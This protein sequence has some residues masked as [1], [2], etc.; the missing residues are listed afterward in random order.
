MYKSP[1]YRIYTHIVLYHKFLPKVNQCQTVNLTNSPQYFGR[2]IQI[3]AFMAVQYLKRL[4]ISNR[5]PRPSKR[6]LPQCRITQPFIL[7]SSICNKLRKNIK[8]HLQIAFKCYIIYLWGV[9]PYK[10]PFLRP[11][12]RYARTTNS[13]RRKSQ[14]QLKLLSM[15][16]AVSA[17]LHSDRCLMLPVMR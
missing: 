10:S 8:K 1:S 12:E 11:Q 7:F 2:Y 14:C 16:S 9:C 5:Q 3:A 15:V 17:V 4:Q 13:F 6:M